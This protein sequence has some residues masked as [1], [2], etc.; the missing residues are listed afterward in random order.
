MAEMR[1]GQRGIAARL[2]GVLLAIVTALSMLIFVIIAAPVRVAQAAPVG[3]ITID[4]QWDRGADGQ[5]ALAGD[6][7]AIVRIA[8]AELDADTG[9]IRA[10]HTLKPFSSFDR[11]WAKLTSSELN[12]AAKQ[13][14]AYVTKHRQYAETGVTD[15]AGRTYFTDLDA[16]IYLIARTAVAS[17]NQRY[18]CDPFLV[19]VPETNSG[20]PTYAVT[21]EPKF[22]DNGGITPPNP[23]PSPNPSP[24][25]NNPSEPS[26]PTQPTT[27]GSQSTPKTPANTGAAVSVIALAA[28]ALTVTAL[29]IRDL[30]RG[31]QSSGS[32][33][34]SRH[35]VSRN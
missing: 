15:G 9:A 19:A 5:T 6:T 32:S 10:F 31:R 35:T 3:S 11:D 34:N 20:T 16:G 7:Y 1:N 27:P 29:I 4:A 25:P 8:S 21:A 14:D 23:N 18:D 24:E 13:L 17:A 33:M 26:K 22:S 30:R 12:A 2:C 28:I